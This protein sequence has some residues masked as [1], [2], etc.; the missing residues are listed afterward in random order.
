M[1]RMRPEFEPQ[2][3]PD[4]M[5]PWSVYPDDP[6]K[7]DFTIQT[8]ER[9]RYADPLAEKD[10]DGSI[11]HPYA[12]LQTAVNALE[13]GETLYLRGGVFRIASPVKIAG[14]HDVTIASYGRELAAVDGHD[15]DTDSP[16]YHHEHGLFT[17]ER[18]DGV[19]IENL[20]FQN[21]HCKGIQIACSNNVEVSFCEVENTFACGIAVWDTSPLA[22][23]K[24]AFRGFKILCNS[25]RKANTWDML[26]KGWR[27]VGEPPHEAISMAG[28]A[29]F[30]VA[31]NHVFECGK[32]G[33]DVKENSRDGA[34][35]HNLVE[36][37][38]RQGLYADAW[39]GELTN[40]TFSHNIVYCNRGAGL[41]LSVEG[42]GS[43]LSNVTFEE[44]QVIRNF[45]T[46]FFFSRWGDDLLRENVVV[47][48]NIFTANGHGPHYGSGSL[49]WITG[50]MFFYSDNMKNVTVE[51]NVFSDN[52]TFEIG[53]SERYGA[54]EASIRRTL[55]EKGIV[56]R[57]NRVDYRG[58]TVF[59]VKVGWTDNW[60]DVL[61]Y[62]GEDASAGAPLR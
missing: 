58:N 17:V 37:C 38:D 30:E 2:E 45:G 35:H 41:A 20:R 54:D 1:Q 29:D 18:C 46:G 61:P 4:P 21:S 49:F 51:D 28:A 39:F 31:Y 62:D 9:V 34:V 47:R 56:I 8:G 59:P 19:I 23:K 43:H 44:N 12:D 53:F 50:G 25:V 32:E 40:V 22:E 7:P 6:P 26:P 57:R 15:C 24:N 5:I 60:A 42:R 55:A 48:G 3:K 11:D 16:G 13:E 14:K 10:G 33:I 52:A 27:K 36:H